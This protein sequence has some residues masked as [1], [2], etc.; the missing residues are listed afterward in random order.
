MM[1]SR[2]SQSLNKEER[3]VGLGNC[4]WGTGGSFWSRR[5]GHIKENLKPAR[6]ARWK[7]A[8]ILLVIRGVDA[9]DDR[10]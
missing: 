7:N 6:G 8:L 5:V 3:G 9:G 4:P 1:C 10:S 2:R